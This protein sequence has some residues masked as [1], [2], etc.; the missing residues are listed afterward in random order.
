MNT[1]DSN[2]PI[3]EPSDREQLENF[4]IFPK[5]VGI[6]EGVWIRLDADAKEIERFTGVV[7]KKI[8]DNQW[9]QTNT[10]QFA[11]GRIVT[12]N[13]VGV[14]AGKDAIKIESSEPPFC[15]YTTL[16]EEYGE[17]LIIFRIWDKATS[18]LLGVETIN[19]SDDNTCIRTS[20]GFTAEGK[21]RGGMTI[22]EH[23]VG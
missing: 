11:D 1:T 7:T 15:N 17:N 20:Q 12:Q 23:R 22:V 8:V 2:L 6:W 16:A 13:F 10:Y 3:S 4:K 21:F 19:L 9:V 14:V 5:H 18:V